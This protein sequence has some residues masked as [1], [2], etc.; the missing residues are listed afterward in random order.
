M[1]MRSVLVHYS[2]CS[3]VLC[4]WVNPSSETAQ[5]SVLFAIL[6]PKPRNIMRS[7]IRSTYRTR[8]NRN[9]SADRLA[10]HRACVRLFAFAL[11]HP[12]AA[13]NQDATTNITTRQHTQQCAWHTHTH[14]HETRTHAGL[15]KR[16]RFERKH[17][18]AVK[19][20]TRQK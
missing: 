1:R 10:C 12:C 19:Q 7:V 2:L 11:L 4:L 13:T 20:Y 14:T 9:E 6:N 15:R 5:H 18:R 16:D 17:T 3:Y 8:S